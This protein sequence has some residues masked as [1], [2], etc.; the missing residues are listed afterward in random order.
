MEKG[1]AIYVKI[2]MNTYMLICLQSLN[3][4]ANLHFITTFPIIENVVGYFLF[5]SMTPYAQTP[6]NIILF[7]WNEHV[8]LLEEPRAIV[9][10]LVVRVVYGLR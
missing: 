5:V 4:H 9:W 7:C 1:S 3:C 10:Q 6:E 2:T 8:G